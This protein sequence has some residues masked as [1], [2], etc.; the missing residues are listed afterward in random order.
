MKRKSQLKIIVDI[1][2][3][4]GLFFTMGYQ[5]WGDS[6]HKRV[7]AIMLLLYILH[8]ALNWRWYKGLFLGKYRPVRMLHS[9]INVSV[10][11]AMGAVIY[12]GV[13]LSKEIALGVVTEPISFA[14]G[15]HV[16]GSYWGFVGTALHLGFHL[17]ALLIKCLRGK[18]LHWSWK[19]IAVVTVLYGLFAFAKRDFLGYL[20]LHSDTLLVKGNDSVIVFYVELAAVMSMFLIAAY[21]GQRCLVESGKSGE[22]KEKERK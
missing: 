9:L 15:I 20:L 8:N 2:M 1:L 14:R 21:K 22:R 3:T 7:G 6:A 10:L 18:K 16:L 12:S 5:F 19:G 13:L 4:A 17:N 11:L